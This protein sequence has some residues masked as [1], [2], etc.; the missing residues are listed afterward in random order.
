M[1][2]APPPGICR[3][4]ESRDAR[5]H[6]IRRAMLLGRRDLRDQGGV[7]ECEAADAPDTR[8]TALKL[9][10]GEAAIGLLA[11]IFSARIS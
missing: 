11:R 3:L 8:A 1:K 10:S 4:R 9:M 5:T 7:N 2:D 6:D